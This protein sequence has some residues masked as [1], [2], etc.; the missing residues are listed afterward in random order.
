ML[1]PIAEFVVLLFWYSL[2]TWSF[3]YLFLY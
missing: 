2:G 1:N 3:L